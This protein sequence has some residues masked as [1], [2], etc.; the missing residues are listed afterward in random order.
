MEW[1]RLL[2]PLDGSAVAEW[3]VPYAVAIARA[4][5][6]AVRLLSVVEP[7]PRGLTSRS[8]R[9]AASIEQA[10]G[11]TLAS[12]LAGVASDLRDQGVTADSTVVVGAP[13]DVILDAAAEDQVT[14]IVM[15]TQGRGG[16]DRVAMGSVADKVI[17]LTT[18]PILAARPPYLPVP[19][20]REVTLRDLL[21][22]L[23]GSAL[24][25]AAL[26]VAEDLAANTGA[27]LTLLRVE[28]WHTEGIAPLGTV[29]EYVQREEDAAAEA[30]AYL[31]GV[32][33]RV[34]GG[35]RTEVV[36]LRAPTG[37]V[38]ETIA[39]FALHERMDLTVMTT[40]GRGGIRRMV[41]GSIADRL[42][43]AGIPSLLV[44]PLTDESGPTTQE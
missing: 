4:T 11:E 16:I 35:A 29:P 2:V 17:R 6:A 18:R 22:P 15:A 8:E 12:Y 38:A 9:V 44:P 43:R 24:A 39:D 40:R 7:R 20:K 42:V 41:L 27:R 19:A 3:A 23:D 25:E 26:P 31:D 30:R 32:R 5:G 34:Q 21:V 10:A 37:K 36:V 14:M 28:P 33:D 1:T 13:V